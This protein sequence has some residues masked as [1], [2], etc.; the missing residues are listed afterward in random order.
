MQIIALGCSKLI[1]KNKPGS[2]N[3]TDPGFCV[4]HELGLFTVDE[5]CISVARHIQVPVIK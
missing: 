3:K 2:F 4:F 1:D 5:F